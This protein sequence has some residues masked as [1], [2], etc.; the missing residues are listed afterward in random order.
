MADSP[1]LLEV[2]HTAADGPAASLPGG[3]GPQLSAKWIP[4]V[5]DGGS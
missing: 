4:D 1:A 5:V 3:L 2:L